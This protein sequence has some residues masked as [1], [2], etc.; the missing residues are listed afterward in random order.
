MAKVL[1]KKFLV[2]LKADRLHLRYYPH[3]NSYLEQYQNSL[4]F[5]KNILEWQIRKNGTKTSTPSVIIWL[6]VI[7]YPFPKCTVFSFHNT[8]CMIC[9]QPCWG[10]MII[11]VPAVTLFQLSVSIGGICLYQKCDSLV[12]PCAELQII[13]HFVYSIQS[14]VEECTEGP[15]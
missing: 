2:Q 1:H 9:M 14:Q 7:W 13:G 10:V 4:C 8:F 15:I 12:C 5:K 3:Q 11:Q 6:F